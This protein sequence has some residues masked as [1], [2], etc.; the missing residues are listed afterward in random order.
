MYKFLLSIL[1]ENRELI[2]LL[3]ITCLIAGL[4]K[5]VDWLTSL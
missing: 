3:L 1:E 4:F 2:N 5:F